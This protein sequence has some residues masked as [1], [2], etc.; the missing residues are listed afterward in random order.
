MTDFLGFIF[1]LAIVL[2]FIYSLIS[3]AYY[4]LKKIYFFF[5]PNIKLN[6][7]DQ[8]LVEEKQSFK[9]ENI[10]TK[11]NIVK[12][13]PKKEKIINDEDKK[14]IALGVPIPKYKNKSLVYWRNKTYKPIV[15]RIIE[16]NIEEIKNGNIEKTKIG[17]FLKGIIKEIKD[18]IKDLKISG[19]NGYAKYG[20]RI[21]YTPENKDLKL[22]KNSVG[23]SK[24][25]AKIYTIQFTPINWSFN[26]KLKSYDD[27]YREIVDKGEEPPP[28]DHFVKNVI[29]PIGKDLFKKYQPFL[30]K[31]AFRKLSSVRLSPPRGQTLRI[32]F[33]LLTTSKDLVYYN[34]AYLTDLGKKNINQIANEL[35]IV[36]KDKNI[37]LHHCYEDSIF[38]EKSLRVAENNF[39][40]KNNISLVGEG[41][42]SQTELFNKLKSHFNSVEKEYSPKWLKPKRIDIFLKKNKVA[43]EY[44]G[45]Q[46]YSPLQFF[47]GE[48]AFKK[49][50]IDDKK[51]EELCLKNKAS[52]VEWPYDI[53]IN[54]KNVSKLK[55]YIMDNENKIYSINVKSLI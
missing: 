15:P 43:I 54:D 26:K 35:D 8:T 41:W 47:G 30:D 51:K 24:N 25:I 11:K 14:Y 6:K 42:T 23:Y 27:F 38:R 16:Y 46:H 12:K 20:D 18:P 34:Q 44:H 53:D 4:Y 10:K 5:N 22:F 21:K 39:R 33:Y 1:G 31:F 49:R 37:S 45:F 50:Q 17:N 7:V 29:S 13:L 55:K 19:L 9:R 40:K 52:F 2:F 28:W 36:F 32:I 48:K 3:I